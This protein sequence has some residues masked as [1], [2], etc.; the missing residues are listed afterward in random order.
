VLPKLQQLL[1]EKGTQPLQL[2]T[3]RLIGITESAADKLAEEWVEALQRQGFKKLHWGTQIRFPE[4]HL[5]FYAPDAQTA[6]AFEQIQIF[7]KTEAPTALIDFD[8]ILPEQ[9]LHD[10]LIAKGL[11][12]AVAES[13][14]GGY[15]SSRL[16]AQ[17]NAST[18]YLGGTISYANSAKVK[19]LGVSLQTLEK[20]GAVSAECALE[21]ATRAAALHG[22]D[23]G[24][25]ITGILGPGGGS[26]GKPLGTAFVGLVTEKL[27]SLDARQ[28]VSNYQL[29]RDRLMNRE[30]LTVRVL[31][32]L[33]EFVQTI[34]NQ[35]RTT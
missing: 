3:C 34:P 30:E 32:K 31:L 19:P 35:R 6:K 13:C 18:Y 10:L 16:L 5:I 15:L 33:S 27:E 7:A 4:V 9:K 29:R 28:Q 12:L 26:Y 14:T 2:L 23:I 22:A 11:T 1:A 20:H 17:P 8:E 25:G 24:V 21:M